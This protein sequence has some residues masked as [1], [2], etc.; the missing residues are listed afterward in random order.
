MLSL[1]LPKL[2]FLSIHFLYPSVGFA[3]TVKNDENS[4]VTWLEKPL[5]A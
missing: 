3:C 4:F 1:I 2:M 5:L